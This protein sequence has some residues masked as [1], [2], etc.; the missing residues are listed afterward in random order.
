MSF[1]GAVRLLIAGWDRRD[2][3]PRAEH[4]PE[5]APGAA[6]A[7]ARGERRG[8]LTELAPGDACVTPDGRA[9]CV[10]AVSDGTSAALVCE[11]A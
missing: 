10:V 11:L 2:P 7:W 9:G 8:A 5:I 1:S 6:A 4:L 3:A